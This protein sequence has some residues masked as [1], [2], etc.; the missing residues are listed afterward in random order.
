MG[1]IGKS[2]WGDFYLFINLIIF[3]VWDSDFVFGVRK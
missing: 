1:G 3:V 2:R